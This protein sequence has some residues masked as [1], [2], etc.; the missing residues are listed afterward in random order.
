MGMAGTPADREI[1]R[2]LEKRVRLLE[3]RTLEL[4]SQGAL[5]RCPAQGSSHWGTPQHLPPPQQRH[6]NILSSVKL[7]NRASLPS[8]S[9][10]PSSS[11]MNPDAAG[12]QGSKKGGGS[13]LPLTDK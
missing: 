13:S 6:F 7:L 12:R 2:D 4:L 5:C 11:T 8:S 9:S 10:S 3:Q 1:M